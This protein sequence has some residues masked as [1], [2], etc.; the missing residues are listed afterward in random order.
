M[1]SKEVKLV[2]LVDEVAEVDRD[3]LK[4]T[5][6]VDRGKLRKTITVEP[7]SLTAYERQILGDLAKV[8]P[9]L[10][11][12]GYVPTDQIAGWLRTGDPGYITSNSGA[13][14]LLS[15]YDVDTAQE[16]VIKAALLF[17]K[18]VILG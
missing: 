12:S 2:N 14:T 18:F 16:T 15:Q 9:I 1:C 8:M 4:E 5:L 13:R 7:G 3:K 11:Q 6:K 17:R 10:A